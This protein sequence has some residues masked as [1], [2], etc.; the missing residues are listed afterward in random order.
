MVWNYPTEREGQ[1]LSG[2]KTF[3]NR[4]ALAFSIAYLS[5][6]NPFQQVLIGLSLANLLCY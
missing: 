1:G 6:P 4:L 3:L 5:D 2:E